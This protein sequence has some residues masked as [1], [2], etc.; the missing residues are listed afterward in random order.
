M[1]ITQ[2]LSW[3][4]F[5]R[6]VLDQTRRPDFPV[7]ERLRF[8]SIWASN[9]DEFFAARISRMFIENRGSDAYQALLREV[10][11]QTDLASGTYRAFLSELEHLGIRI[12]PVAE[13]TAEET[14]YFGAYLAEEVAPKTDTIRVDALRD[15][16]SQALYFASGSGVLQYLIRLPEGLPRV[17]EVPGREGAYVRMGELLRLR[18]DLFLADENAKLHELRIIRLALIDQTATDW[19][20]LP[21]ALEGRLEGHV[22]HLEVEQGFPAHWTEGIREALGLRPEE[23]IQ[24]VPPLDLRFVSTI[25]DHAP[26]STKFEPLQSYKVPHFEESPFERIDQG[27]LLLFHPYQSYEAVETYARSAATDPE[28]TAIRATLYRVGEDNVLANALIAA[29]KAGKDVAVLLEARARFDE[30]TNM[31]WALRLRNS[32][33]EVLSLPEKKVHAKVFWVRRGTREYIPIGTGNYNTVNGRLY[34]DFSLFS[35]DPRLTADVKCFFDALQAGKPPELRHLRT[36]PA[37]RE[38]MLDRIRAEASPQGRI[39]AKFNHL[40]DPA[41]LDALEDAANRGAR[42]DLLVRTTLTRLTDKFQARS[43]VGRF[44]EHARVIAFQRDGTWEVW[45]GSFDAMARNFDRR[46]ELLFPVLDPQARESLLSELHA[47]LEDDMNTFELRADGGLDAHW[48]GLKNAQRP[49]DHRSH[50]EQRAPDGV[51]VPAVP[52]VPAAPASVL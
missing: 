18:A 27:D 25:V 11:Q 29:A 45:A 38:L 4:K 8:L 43:L 32:G 24:I 21:E 22:S 44:L 6:R 52:A 9:L 14:R 36:G 50:P 12:L 15:I 48:G 34:T 40:T 37:A 46:Y 10:R 30:L 41:V 19:E 28:V 23:V 16:R 1:Q 7:L 26:P 47:Q 42:V 20:D 17:L 5:N 33:V 3:L 39:I 49:D 2:E 13:L 51:G 35:C 31:E